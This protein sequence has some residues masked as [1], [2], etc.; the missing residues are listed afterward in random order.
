MTLLTVLESNDFSSGLASRFRISH[1]L[2]DFSSRLSLR[3]RLRTSDFGVGFR[4]GIEIQLSDL[5]TNHLLCSERSV[6][7]DEQTLLLLDAAAHR[8]GGHVRYFEKKEKA[9]SSQR[10]EACIS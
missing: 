6:D 2:L 3:I 1:V 9:V 5:A 4:V 10:Q 8:A 7:T